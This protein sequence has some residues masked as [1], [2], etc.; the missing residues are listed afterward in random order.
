MFCTKCGTSIEEGSKFC[1]KC[2]TPVQGEKPASSSGPAAPASRPARSARS[3]I[4][5]W[6]GLAA[7]CL[8]LVVTGRIAVHFLHDDPTPVNVDDP[9]VQGLMLVESGPGYAYVNASGNFEFEDPNSS[10]G[11]QNFDYAVPFSSNGKAIVSDDGQQFYIIDSR[12]KETASIDLTPWLSGSGMSGAAIFLPFDE[13]GF[14]LFAIQTNTSASSVC[15]GIVDAKGRVAVP[16]EYMALTGFNSN[17]K[18]IGTK[19]TSA[20]D[21]QTYLVDKNGNETPLDT[22]A[23]PIPSTFSMG[24]GSVESDGL[25]AAI[26][27]DGLSSSPAPEDALFGYLNTS[28]EWAIAPKYT[29]CSTFSQG[30]AWVSDGT[31]WYYIDTEGNKI[32]ADYDGVSSFTQDGLALVMRLDE[33]ETEWF[34]YINPNGQEVIPLQ[35]KYGSNFSNG[36]ALVRREGQEGCCYIDWQGNPVTGDIYS[37]SSGKFDACGL[38]PVLDAGYLRSDSE[39]PWGYLSKDGSMAISRMV[40]PEYFEDVIPGRFDSKLK[41]APAIIEPEG[42][43]RLIDQSG[44]VLGDAE[45]SNYFSTRQFLQKFYGNDPW[46]SDTFYWL[47]V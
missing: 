25:V 6:A 41:L 29:E 9:F 1:S 35:Y 3:R 24:A 36:R 21:A 27:L 34:G 22:K 4:W 10:N 47:A 30:C 11:F 37:Q 32:S 18:A 5:G 44:N 33:S 2:G 7:I 45:F 14:S 43:Y 12:G 40:Y 20:Q 16:P 42:D 23:L 19:G 38:A 46:I 39:I 13:N 28:G 26:S 8:A 15:W 17:G 31:S